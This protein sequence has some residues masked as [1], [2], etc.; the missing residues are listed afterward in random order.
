MVTLLF[1]LPFKHTLTFWCALSPGLRTRDRFP[2]VAF[3]SCLS[4]NLQVQALLPFLIVH[5]SSS[6]SVGVI[7][8]AG[9]HTPLFSGLVEK[10]CFVKVSVRTHRAPVGIATPPTGLTVEPLWKLKNTDFLDVSPEGQV[11]VINWFSLEF[12]C[13]S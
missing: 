12:I 5:P 8:G 2:V 7:L 4:K 6:N 1:P 3:L 13:L 9:P 10:P 11:K